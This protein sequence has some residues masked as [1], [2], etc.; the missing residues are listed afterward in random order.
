MSR[1][2]ILQKLSDIFIDVFDNEELVL[3]EETSNADI[4]GWDSL[5]LIH[6]LVAVEDVFGIRIKAENAYDLKSV[7]KIIDCIEDGLKR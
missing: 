1:E 7:G 4:N 2:I 6:I 5:Q 3:T